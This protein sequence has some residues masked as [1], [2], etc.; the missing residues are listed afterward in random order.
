LVQVHITADRFIH[1]RVP[2]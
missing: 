2:K 1:R